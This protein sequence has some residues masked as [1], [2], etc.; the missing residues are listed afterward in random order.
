MLKYTQ[1]IRYQVSKKIK[2]PIHISIWQ[3]AS[4][5]KLICFNNSV[6][7]GEHFIVMFTFFQIQLLPHGPINFVVTGYF[8]ILQNVAWCK[9]KD[10]CKN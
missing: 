3:I 9:E 10:S 4:R 6:R 7:L 2:L 1:L 5:E 8:W